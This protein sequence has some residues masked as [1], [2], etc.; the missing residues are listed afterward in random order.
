[1]GV[2]PAAVHRLLSPAS[3]NM[4]LPP[5]CNKSFEP[6]PLTGWSRLAV[7]TIVGPNDLVNHMAKI[8]ALSPIE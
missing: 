4:S 3:V 6:F 7:Q 5:F 2:A 8:K 1:M